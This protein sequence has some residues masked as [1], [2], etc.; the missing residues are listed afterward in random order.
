ME[1]M[2]FLHT[3]RRPPFP[4][5]LR[6]IPSGAEA[7][8]MNITVAPHAKS[9]RIKRGQRGH[10][11]RRNRGKFAVRWEWRTANRAA[12]FVGKILVLAA[13]ASRQSK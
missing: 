11:S 10:C 1:V 7:Y 9:G 13:D 2:D 12:I 6:V 8:S 4:R 3:I 5:A